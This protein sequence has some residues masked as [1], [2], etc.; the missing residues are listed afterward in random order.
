[1]INTAAGSARPGP[2]KGVVLH[3]LGPVPQPRFDLSAVAEVAVKMSR[4][5]TGELPGLGG[6]A[7]ANLEEWLQVALA[8]DRV[9]GLDRRR[10]GLMTQFKEPDSTALSRLRG[11]AF[12]NNQTLDRLAPSVDSHSLPSPTCTADPTAADALDQSHS[13]EVL[14]RGTG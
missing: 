8:V 13:A 9:K 12:S 4:F 11:Y 14:D 2:V 7:D 6:D 1:V 10:H 5:L 3:N